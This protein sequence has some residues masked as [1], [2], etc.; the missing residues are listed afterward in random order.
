M[1]RQEGVTFEVAVIQ[2]TGR[3]VVALPKGHVDEGETPAEAALRE[4]GE[5]TGLT[6]R[7][8][9]S[10]GEIHYVYRF[11]GQPVSKTVAF[12][13]FRHV[14]GEIDRIVPAMRVEVARAYWLPLGEAAALLSY[15]GERDVVGRAVAALGGG[16]GM[17]VNP[18]RR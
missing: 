10:L 18:G 6:A 17:S 5:E 4:V 8:D 13:L 14:G 16:Q 2:P 9:Q 3:R 1:V 11:R 7:L 12:F 15:Q